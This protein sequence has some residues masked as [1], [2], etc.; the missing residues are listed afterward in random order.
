M[1]A[2]S[3]LALAVILAVLLQFAVLP[4]IFDHVDAAGSEQGGQP[5]YESVKTVVTKIIQ[6]ADYCTI[7][8]KKGKNGNVLEESG[9][10]CGLKKGS[11]IT[12]NY[13]VVYKQ[14]CDWRGRN[15]RSQITHQYRNAH[16]G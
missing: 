1:K 6:R 12:I 16:P 5:V 8:V 2:I 11:A 10:V 3:L 4:A 7:W 9:P 14:V 13:Q 15:C